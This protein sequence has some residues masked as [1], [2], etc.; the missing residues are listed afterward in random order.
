MVLKIFFI[1]K[2]QVCT[3]YGCSIL[4]QQWW[5][6]GQLWVPLGGMALDQ[7]SWQQASLRGH[8]PGRKEGF[9]GHTPWWR[10]VWK[11]CRLCFYKEVPLKVQVFPKNDYCW[12]E[13]VLSVLHFSPHPVSRRTRFQGIPRLM[14]TL[15]C[16]ASPYSRQ[17]PFALSTAYIAAP[18]EFI[19][20]SSQAFRSQ[21]LLTNWKNSIF[22]FVSLQRIWNSSSIICS[23]WACML[24]FKLIS[25][26]DRGARLLR[27]SRHL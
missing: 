5:G 20:P 3:L 23:R 14:H 24:P 22:L 1:K 18:R 19:S 4:S 10:C 7:G 17:M 6:G 27:V 8:L 2:W 21:S 26:T 12:V 15:M 16:L 13:R 9:R 25:H 11:H